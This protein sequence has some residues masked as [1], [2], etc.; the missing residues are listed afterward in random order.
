MFILVRLWPA[1]ELT[2]DEKRAAISDSDAEH[3]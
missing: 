2:M 1:A 3:A